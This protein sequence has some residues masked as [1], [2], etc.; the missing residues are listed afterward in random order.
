VRSAT[1]QNG[2]PTKGFAVFYPV[3]TFLNAEKQP[4]ATLDWNEA[5]QELRP[6]EGFAIPTAYVKLVA[7]MTRYPSARY[8][9]VHTDAAYVGARQKL[10]YL[11]P[12]Y[13]L[14]G[15]ALLEMTDS[16]DAAF[17]I[18]GAPDAPS[19]NLKIEFH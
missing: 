6:P 11:V 18:S 3:V 14:A 1:F 2:F 4:V 9:V 16:K 5:Q 13:S 15:E 12:G 7:D 8:V 17:D 10:H 19:G